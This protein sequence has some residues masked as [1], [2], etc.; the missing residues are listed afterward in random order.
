[1][2][3]EDGNFMFQWQNRLLPL[4]RFVKLMKGLSSLRDIYQ[5]SKFMFEWQNQLFSL[6]RFAKLM[7]V[8]PSVGD[9]YHVH[10]SFGDVYFQLAVLREVLRKEGEEFSVIIDER[11]K[12]LTEVALN[13]KAQVY[14]TE[15]VALN[16]L[17][18][19]LGIVGRLEGL[20]IRMLPTLYPNCGEMIYASKLQYSHFLRTLVMSNR[21]GQ[22]DRIEDD[23][24]LESE[25]LDII[26]AT[27]CPPGKTVLISADNN[28]HLELP[29]HV[30][31]WI[32][33]ITQEMGWSILLNDSGLNNTKSAVNLASCDLRRIKVPPHLP[34]TLARI[35]GAYISGTNGFATIQALFSD[36]CRGLHFINGFN[37][38]NGRQRDKGRNLVNLEHFFHSITWAET[39]LGIQTEVILDEKTDKVELT[40][41]IEIALNGPVGP[42]RPTQIA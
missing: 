25:A 1:V 22:F 35:A 17:L 41:I 5:V 30:W 31:G 3:E 37:T 36:R 8:L 2:D 27:G 10:G 21:E 34:C 7:R 15:S 42:D 23:V 24:S 18:S 12:R 29:E 16:S 4:A 9:I 32:I 20:P 38:E 28:T 40:K 19:S 13:S 33:E 11:Y 6:A 14:F 39:F 26:V